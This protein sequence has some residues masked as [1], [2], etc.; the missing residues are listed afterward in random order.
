[1]T[2]ANPSRALS[3]GVA[4]TDLCGL[5]WREK[6]STN[7]ISL[8]VLALPARD[9]ILAASLEAEALCKGL[10]DSSDIDNLLSEETAAPGIE[11]FSILISAQSTL[12]F[13]ALEETLPPILLGHRC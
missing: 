1:M 13:N 8:S 11:V 9:N 4:L 12:L 3:D 2:P 6:S 5:N 7:F 10:L